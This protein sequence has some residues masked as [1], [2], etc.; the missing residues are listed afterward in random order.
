M[1]ID[2]QKQKDIL[3]AE[4]QRLEKEILEVA[5]KEGD[6]VWEAKQTEKECAVDREDIADSMENY[7]SNFLITEVLKK[8]INDIKDALDKI[9]S[10]TYGTCEVC[11]SEIEAR[12]LEVK[13]EA[14]TCELHMK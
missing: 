12:R 11:Q 5:E 14:R 1:N 2:I 7:A 6:S 4:L 8:E 3:K 13:P 10:N 9:D